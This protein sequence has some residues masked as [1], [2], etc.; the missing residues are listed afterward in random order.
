MMLWNRI[1]KPATY[2]STAHEILRKCKQ[3]K[4]QLHL[5]RVVLVVDQ[6]I[7][8]KAME[9]VWCHSQQFKGVYFVMGGVHI[10]CNLLYSTIETVELFQ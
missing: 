1:N 5:A 6:A 3:V 9:I 2:M 7:F 4:S 8:A 10:T